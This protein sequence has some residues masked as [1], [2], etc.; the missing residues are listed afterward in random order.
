M[1]QAQVSPSSQRLRHPF[2]LML[3]FWV[4]VA[5]SIAVVIRRFL[6][7][8][9]PSP[10]ARTPMAELSANQQI[11]ATFAS[12]AI[13]TMAHILVAAIFVLIAVGVLFRLSHAKWLQCFFFIFG[14]ITGATAY[15]MN[16]Y[17]VGGWVERSAVLVFN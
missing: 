15:A 6:A 3:A 13:L 11:N 16:Q 12:H 1:I 2:S 17:A 4:C 7:L 14:A 9:R 10:G 8:I 5:I